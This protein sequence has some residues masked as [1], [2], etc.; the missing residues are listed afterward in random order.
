MGKNA[1]YSNTKRLISSVKIPF[2]NSFI[3][4]RKKK[5]FEDV[6]IRSTIESKVTEKK[7]RTTEKKQKHTG[8]KIS[9]VEGKKTRKK[10]MPTR[11]KFKS[12]EKKI[13]LNGRKIL[14]KKTNQFCHLDNRIRRINCQDK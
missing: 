12:N 7:I 13:G 14:P 10:I 6:R 8:R 9:S 11:I 3:K 2:L 5:C 4:R 1:L